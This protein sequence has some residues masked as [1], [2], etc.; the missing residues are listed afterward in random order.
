MLEEF[1]VPVQDDEAELV[2]S[3]YRCFHTCALWAPKQRPGSTLGQ[4]G[5]LVYFGAHQYSPRTR[6]HL[7][8]A[9]FMVNHHELA[10]TQVT[11]TKLST[12]IQQPHIPAVL[13][14]GAAYNRPGNSCKDDDNVPQDISQLNHQTGY[15][16]RI[17]IIFHNN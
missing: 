9:D 13:Q 16:S 3:T 7:A 10:R 5:L 17:V 15:R 2:D 11:A 4:N 6:W 12:S 8:D 14:R 1:N